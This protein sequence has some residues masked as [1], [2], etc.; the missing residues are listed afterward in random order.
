MLRWLA[1]VY[2][3]GFFIKIRSIISN[4]FVIDCLGNF[5]CLG[6]SS[7]ICRHVDIHGRATHHYSALTIAAAIDLTDTGKRLNIHLW[8]LECFTFHICLQVIFRH[9]GFPNLS[10][11]LGHFLIA[12]YRI[13]RLVATT[14]EFTD[15]DRLTTRL[16]DIHRDRATDGTTDIITSKHA[17]ESTVSN[18]QCH[19]TLDV[20]SLSSTVCRF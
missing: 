5:I 8:V 2:R 19:V 13:A 11:S 7:T 18:I 3:D 4:C 16:L 12:A 10:G 17:L 20:C 1:F 15:D 9:T 14:I 6:L